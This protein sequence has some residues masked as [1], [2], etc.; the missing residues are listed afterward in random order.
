MAVVLHNVD[1]I[2]APQVVIGNE[3]AE[4]FIPLVPKTKTI[5]DIFADSPVREPSTYKDS[6]YE[7]DGS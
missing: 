7:T 5:G 1:A 4:G 3:Q 6:V 2:S